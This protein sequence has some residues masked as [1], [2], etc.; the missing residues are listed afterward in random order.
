LKINGCCQVIDQFGD[1]IPGLHAAG[2]VTGGLH[3]KNYLPGVMSSS[4]MT[5]GITAGR[6]AVKEPASV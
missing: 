3:T 1:V 6:S 4:G 2:E 5:Q